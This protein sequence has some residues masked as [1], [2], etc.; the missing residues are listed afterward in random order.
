[1]QTKREP[2]DVLSH[3]SGVHASNMEPVHYRITQARSASPSGWKLSV[4]QNSLNPKSTASQRL[5]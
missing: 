3:I 1:M 4:V 2:L 5:P